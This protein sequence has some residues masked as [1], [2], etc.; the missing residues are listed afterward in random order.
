[1]YNKDYKHQPLDEEDGYRVRLEKT[2]SFF[3]MTFCWLAVIIMTLLAFSLFDEIR[4]WGQ[5]FLLFVWWLLETSIPLLG[6]IYFTVSYRRHR[7]EYFIIT[8]DG[9]DF[10]KSHVFQPDVELQ[11]PWSKI[12]QIRIYPP[13][14]F[15]ST[16]HSTWLTEKWYGYYMS[17]EDA[18]ESYEFSLHWT[19]KPKMM[20]EVLKKYSSGKIKIEVNK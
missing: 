10:Y 16:P 20:V 19:I 6:A 5:L 1:M 8:K 17:I 9:V 4:W 11:R 15:W 3:P 2:T 7:K 13:R 12:E 18:L 14:Y